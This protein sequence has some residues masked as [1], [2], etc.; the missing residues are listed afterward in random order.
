M[1]CLYHLR[2]WTWRGWNSHC[3]DSVGAEIAHHSGYMGEMPSIDC[4]GAEGMRPVGESWYV[5]LRAVLNHYDISDTVVAVAD[6]NVVPTV[7]AVVVN[8]CAED[9]D[10]MSTVSGHYS[11]H[12]IL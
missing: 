9:I 5:H 6:G 12:S 3:I 7:L 10:R 8:S 1:P 11:A 4:T 2:W